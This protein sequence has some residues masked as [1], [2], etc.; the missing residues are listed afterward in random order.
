MDEFDKFFLKYR[1]FYKYILS[2]IAHFKKY[3]K[4]RKVCKIEKGHLKMSKI[5][6]PG[7]LP[8]RGIESGSPALQ[9]A[10]LPSKPP[11]KSQNT[12]RA[13]KNVQKI[14]LVVKVCYKTKV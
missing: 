13:F 5:L 1:R 9:A 4:C 7:T 8:D 11:G 2:E 14:I 12:K 6:S 3:L 10:T